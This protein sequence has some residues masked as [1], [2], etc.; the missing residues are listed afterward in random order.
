VYLKVT[1]LERSIEFYHKK[2]GLDITLDWSSMGAAFLSSGG[3]HHHI[4]INTWHSLDGEGHR[5][6]E[7]GLK[8]I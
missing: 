7:T 3:Y 8:K 4:G 2:L 5:D 6:D 1:T